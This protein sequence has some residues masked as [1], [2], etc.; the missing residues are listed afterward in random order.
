MLAYFNQLEYFFLICFLLFVFISFFFKLKKLYLKDYSVSLKKVVIPSVFSSAKICEIGEKVKYN[1]LNIY[2]KKIDK[3][4]I[5]ATGIKLDKPIYIENLTNLNFNYAKDLWLAKKIYSFNLI[6]FYADEQNNFEIL[7][8][9]FNLDAKFL[10]T[11]DLSKEIKENLYNLN[12]NH[13][14]YVNYNSMHCNQKS[15]NSKKP[16]LKKWHICEKNEIK[17]LGDFSK[18]TIFKNFYLDSIFENKNV[19]LKV[20]QTFFYGAYYFFGI[21]IKN[22]KDKSVKDIKFKKDQNVKI[23]FTK[24]IHCNE[25]EYF[26]ICKEKKYFKIEGLLNKKNYF[27]YSSIKIAKIEIVKILHS[28]NYCLKCIINSKRDWNEQNLESNFLIYF[29]EKLPENFF[30]FDYTELYY[31]IL[32]CL[33]SSFSI[34][35]KSDNNALNFYFNNYLPS[36]IIT[37]GIEGQTFLQKCDLNSALDNIYT[38]NEFFNLLKKLSFDDLISFHKSKKI[39]AILVYNL[40]KN[41]LFIQR[42][43][44]FYINKNELTNYE[45]KL[46]I[47]NKIKKIKIKTGDSKKIII[48]DMTYHNC[49]NISIKTLINHQNFEA[50]L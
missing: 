1:Q 38:E 24:I 35:L 28:K 31:K 48:D 36:K 27:F 33:R 37:E 21:K 15:N 4:L 25:L 6:V 42:N 41:K 46:F 40:M 3:S 44:F 7:K 17:P 19:A 5:E 34:K 14:L 43:N 26:K 29:G 30:N 2:T 50:Y 22:S 12:I 49:C 47:E 13:N 8:N 20:K 45:L 10:N 39:S 11:N 18:H 16:N 23:L 32:Y 9:L